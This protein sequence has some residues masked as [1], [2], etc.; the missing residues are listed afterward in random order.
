MF[1]RIRQAMQAFRKPKPTVDLQHELEELIHWAEKYMEYHA[2]K[3]YSSE[4]GPTG[5]WP[6]I[7]RA[8]A[9]LKTHGGE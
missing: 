3:F 6:A 4:P 1:R 5:L 2:D 9:A 8:K 7:N